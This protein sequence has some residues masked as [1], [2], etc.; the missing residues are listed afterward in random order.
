MLL[1]L[2][3]SLISNRYI[4]SCIVNLSMLLCIII[5]DSVTTVDNFMSLSIIA[6]YYRSYVN[7]ILKG[8]VY[9]Y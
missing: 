6:L 1:I 5:H 4:Y 9:A 8:Y 7:L 2:T 3:Y